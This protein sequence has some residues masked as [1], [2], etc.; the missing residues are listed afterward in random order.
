MTVPFIQ[1]WGVNS[2]ES[3]AERA[4]A[5]GERHLDIDALI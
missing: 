4:N 5:L 1:C 2:G 3:L